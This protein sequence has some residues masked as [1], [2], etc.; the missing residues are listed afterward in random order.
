MKRFGELTDQARVALENGDHH[1]LASLMTDNFELR[2]KTY[3][4]AVVGARN[5]QMVEIVRRHGGH[6]KFSGSGGAIV[7]FVPDT[8]SI[9]PLQWD[10]E[11]GGFVFIKLTPIGSQI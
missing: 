4:D 8:A 6:A 11:K 2:R 5:L 1:T 10:L 3:G 9:K 7:V